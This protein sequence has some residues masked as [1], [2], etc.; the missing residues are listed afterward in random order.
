MILER[1]SK[2]RGI[3]Y[4]FYD[5]QGIAD[6]YVSY[7]L[8]KLKEC[9]RDI[10]VV[11]NGTLEAESRERL[12]KYASHVWEREN[13]G[14]D[15][16][17]YKYALEKIGWENLG[18]YDELVLMNHTIMGPVFPLMEMFDSMGA[19]DLDFWGTNIFYKVG[20]DPYGIIECGYIREHLQ[21]H[22][23]VARRSLLESKDYREYWES[24]PK[25]TNYK[26]SVA[27]H[28]TYF[29]HHFSELGYQWQAYAHWDGLE[30]YSEYP[31]LKMPVELMKKTRCPFFKRRS[32]MHDNPNDFLCSTFGEPTAKLLD[33]L[34]EETDYDVDM[35]WENIL[36][37]DN[38]ADLKT[39]ANLNYVLSSTEGTDMSRVVK[40][41]GVAL[42]YH[43]YYE[44]CLADCLHYA[45]SMPPEAD[46]YITVGNEP[47]KA[48]V[49]KAFQDFPNRVTVILVENRGRDVSA[50]LIGAKE[51]VGKYEYICFA[52]DKKVTQ[53]RPMTQ[54]AGWSYKCFESV[55][56]NRTFVNN[57]IRTFE[58]NPR[59][60]ML[61]PAP[62]NHG[63]YYSLLGGEWT[64]NFDNVKKLADKLGLGVSIRK[65]KEPI[66]PIGTIFWFRTKALHLLF[67]ANWEYS[68]F[69]EEP[70]QN[71]GTLS[72]AI[73]RLYPFAVQE[74]GYYPAWIFSDSVA[75]QEITN[76]TYM[77]RRLNLVI[78]ENHLGGAFY[79]DVY[80]NLKNKF[81][82]KKDSLR[83]KLYLD[84]GEGY[85]EANTME[86]PNW[87]EEELRAEFIWPS[88]KGTP[89]S[90]RLD[91]NELGGFA[92]SNIELLYIYS[93]EK[94]RRIPKQNWITNGIVQDD[95]IMF[96]E[97][98]PWID[99]KGPQGRQ[100][101]IGLAV[102]AKVKFT[103]DVV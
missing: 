19:R 2:N 16:A 49:E 66:A 55:L 70:S 35:I 7:M 74:A 34:R 62:P 25:I 13:K 103:G 31:M 27:Y 23:I 57:V 81:E 72:H 73:E 41:K 48:M 56:K 21:S 97:M 100:K 42:I 58:E 43:F 67:E 99:I 4:F 53:L 17:A 39:C 5:R 96:A 54:G 101:P 78:Y 29:T 12:L 94:R 6:R 89:V 79:H 59:L 76:L 82:T 36:R 80:T 86:V 93:S 14:L 75:A 60:G 84:Y 92:L 98:D 46:I 37:C 3:I 90:V 85:N 30:E 32:F 38:Q 28:E 45:A 47:K 83:P 68:D 18:I 65:D 10:F 9:S 33:F 63:G 77:L 87:D 22:F 40:Q 1:G 95:E 71:D 50:L 61:S 51:V 69:P 44:D 24:L 88:K 64:A 102:Y 8:Q 91:P 15:V 20:F 11:V 52:H 26:E